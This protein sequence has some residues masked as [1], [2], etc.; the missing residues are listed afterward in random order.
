MHDHDDTSVRTSS[1]SSEEEL[2]VENEHDYSESLDEEGNE[3]SCM[4]KIKALRAE[5]V[6]CKKERDEYLAGWQRAKADGINARKLFE[7]E[8]SRLEARAQGKVLQGVISALDAFSHAV[9]DASWQSVSPEWRDGVERI[10]SRL[11]NDM[12]RDGVETFGA[13]G[14]SFS[15]HEHECMSV[16]PTPEIEKEDTI[17]QVLQKGY[18]IGTEVIRPAKVVVYQKA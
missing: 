17:A 5:L 10:F 3:A 16:V 13:E 11:E 15:P 6:S 9:H 7:N 2:V 8:R 18:R 12:E 4:Q 1:P 14:D